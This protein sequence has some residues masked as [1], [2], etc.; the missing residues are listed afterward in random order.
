[1]A[2]NVLMIALS[3]TMET[4]QI[5]KWH[6]EVGDTIEMG[7]IICEVETDKAV[8]EYESMNEGTLLK[9]LVPKGSSA[10]VG[11]A[12]AVVGEEGELKEEA[13]APAPVKKKEEKKEE[14][15]KA[16]QPV[17]EKTVSPEKPSPPVK[18]EEILKAKVESGG[19]VK[20]SPLARKIAKKYGID[21]SKIKGSGPNGRIVKE[22]VMKVKDTTTEGVIPKPAKV[23]TSP[24]LQKPQPVTPTV[25][26]KKYQPA[27]KDEII[28]LSGK[29]KVIARR[30]SE[31]KFSAPHYYLKLG[32]IMDDILEAREELNEILPEKV[33][34]NSFFMKF[35][36]EALKQH[37]IVN[38]TWNE[39]S[40]ILHGSIDIGLAVAVPDGLITPIVRDCG[41]KRITQIDKELKDLIARAKSGKLKPEEYQGATFTISNLGSY[42]IEEFTAVINPP[43]S[44]I[45]AL[46]AILDKPEFLDNETI[47]LLNEMKMT[48]SCDHRVI[49]GAAGAEFMRDLKDIMEDPIRALV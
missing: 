16:P 20:A 32:V 27:E 34:L 17:E 44:A 3:P 30:L 4:G 28:P 36:A 2:E 33:S 8:M 29:R 48:L 5:V 14:E 38:S 42:G 26:A 46:G 19:R 9:I 31:S 40:I 7:D 35:A 24:V 1:M 22:D 12:I 49:D 18:P 43:G 39:D 23:K 13:P 11:E 41:N 15:I 10:S 6:K 25:T 45:L 21:I 37:P 47:I